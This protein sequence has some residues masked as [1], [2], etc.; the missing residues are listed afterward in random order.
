MRKYCHMIILICHYFKVSGSSDP[1]PRPAFTSLH[2]F[3]WG[4]ACW[5]LADTSQGHTQGKN[6]Y[7]IRTK[8]G[9]GD[10]T[11]VTSCGQARPGLPTKLSDWPVGENWAQARGEVMSG[12]WSKAGVGRW[13]G[14]TVQ[15]N[16]AAESNYMYYNNYLVVRAVPDSAVM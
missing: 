3:Q 6:R 15:V 11:A 4:A 7:S 8:L 1:D 13:R 12:R 5:V 2:F 14:T 10:V 16:R 9:R